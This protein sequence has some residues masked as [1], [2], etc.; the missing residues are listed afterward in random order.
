MKKYLFIDRDGT[1]IREPENEQ[2]DTLEKMEFLPGVFRNLYLITHLLDY[3][4]VM[5]SN[6]DGLGT[7]SYPEKDFQ[8][9]QDKLLKTLKNEDIQ[10][11][12]V[13][14]DS[15]LP[16]DNSPNRKPN[17][18][19][20]RLY[21]QG[22][23]DREASFVIGDR[24]T[25]IIL[26]R[27][28]GLRGIKIDEE[29][30]SV[31]DELADFCALVG[32][33]WDEIFSYLRKYY[34]TAPIK[35]ETDETSIN[36]S[37]SLDGTGHSDIQT[38]LGFFNHMLDQLARHGKMDLDLNVKGDL[39]VDA[40]HTIEDTGL[41]LGEAFSRAVGNKKGMERYGFSLPMD[42][43]IANCVLDFSGRAHLEWE[44]E[45]NRERV[46]EVPTEMFEH[47]FESFAR[48]ARCTIHIS[49]KGKNEHHKIEAVFKSF[50]RALKMAVKQDVNDVTIP[51]TKGKL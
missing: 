25:D 12:E 40:H 9:V 22:D 17:T 10:F 48:E 4:L 35:R 29:E 37:L 50:A 15:S 27:N 32:Q 8:L 38:G 42:E 44:V 5:V 47:F 31:P 21:L 26:A 43:S 41:A 18:G 49:A 2:V 30:R 1:L 14:I 13:L 20:V 3:R 23:F 11:E 39:D 46:G 7:A 16:K 33:S 36:G 51:T 19:L 34:R 6:Q 24:D 45:L 28:M